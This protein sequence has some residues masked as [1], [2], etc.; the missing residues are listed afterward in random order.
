MHEYTAPGD[1]GIDNVQYEAR[2]VT[3][4]PNPIQNDT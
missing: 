2:T 4:F 3:R 1:A